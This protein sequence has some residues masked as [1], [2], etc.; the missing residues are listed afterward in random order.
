MPRGPEA[1]LSLAIRRAL[2]MVGCRVYSSETPRVRGP[3]GNTP[4]WPDLLVFDLESGR[5][6]WMEL[7]A[8]RNR[9]TE[10]QREFFRVAR[11]CGQECVEV[12]SVDDALAAM[13]FK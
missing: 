3:S 7:K 5:A 13:G 1:K 9:M 8:G 10:S 12:R 4:G 2:K 11:A 6:V